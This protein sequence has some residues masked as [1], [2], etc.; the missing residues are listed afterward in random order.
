MGKET[1]PGLPPTVCFSRKIGV[2]ALEVA[3]VLAKKIG[4]RV[5]DREILDT[6]ANE[7]DLSRQTVARFDERYPGKIAE[8]L[9]LTFGEKAFIRSDYSRHLFEAV[10]ALARTAP[11]IFV[12]RGAHLLLP[13]ERTLA[14]RCICSEAHRV[15]RLAMMLNVTETEAQKTLTRVDKEQR[16]FFKG[17]YGRDG[18]SPYEFDL[19]L[20]F[21][22]IPRP[23]QVAE[24]VHRAF[25]VKFMDEGQGA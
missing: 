20:N 21:D 24:V 5:V 25:Q 17:V 4:Y 9:S 15:R 12:G 19:V 2:G 8:F 3:D 22:H 10:Y 11:T 7:G 18:A 6:I 13:R 14:V 1:E 23:E 16:E